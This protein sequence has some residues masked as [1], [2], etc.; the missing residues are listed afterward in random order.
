[1]R[2]KL[3]LGENIADNGGVKLAYDVSTS[4]FSTKT[5]C[6]I[7]LYYFKYGKYWNPKKNLL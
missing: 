4:D 3:T 5:N 6:L 7:F 2:G 1:V